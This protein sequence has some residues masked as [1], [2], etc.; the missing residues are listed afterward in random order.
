MSIVLVPVFCFTFSDSGWLFPVLGAEW[1]LPHTG[2]PVFRLG[3]VCFLILLEGL[4]FRK[5]DWKG[6]HIC[7]TCK[8][9]NCPGPEQVVFLRTVIW[10]PVPTGWIGTAPALTSL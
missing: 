9:Q 8:W 2:S 1:A 6:L 7:H 10:I 4:D 5:A 3:L